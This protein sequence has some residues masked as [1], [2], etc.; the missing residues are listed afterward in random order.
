M[1]RDNYW[2][3]LKFV[4]IFL[5]VYGHVTPRYLEGSQ[6]NMAIFNFIYMFHM[7]LFIFVSGRFSHI[8]DRK[9]YLK[10]IFKLFETYVVF[11]IIRTTFQVLLGGE[12]G[13]DCLYTPQWTL[14]YLVALI[15]WRLMIYYMPERWLNHRKVL[16]VVSVFISLLAGFIPLGHPFAV[17]RTLTFL[18]FFLLGYYSMDVDIR[19]YINKIPTLCAFSILIVVLAF[20]FMVFGDKSLSFVHHGVFP[21]WTGDLVHTIHHF[22]AR[23]IYI[24]IAIL[25]SIMVMRLVPTNDTFAKWGRKTMFIFIYHTFAINILIELTKRNII[26][27]N[28]ILLFV[29]A[30]IITL[31]LLFLSRFKLLNICLN[32]ISFYRD[33]KDV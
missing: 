13:I 12:L 6:F 31:G 23:I 25:L 22:V 5:V 2:D 28:E 18:P 20:F 29:Y 3:S 32:P 16:I 27:Q 15:Y 4:L 21:Y 26:P 14:W 7:P 19:N 11:Q 17:Q 24:P 30:V 8:R 9:R 33:R 10:G 1:K